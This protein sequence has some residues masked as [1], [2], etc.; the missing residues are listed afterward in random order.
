[1]GVPLSS[2]R[3]NHRRTAMTKD[4]YR[5]PV[6]VIRRD[7]RTLDAWKRMAERSP[8][9]VPP[10]VAKTLANRYPQLRRALGFG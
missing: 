1:M 9:A 8:A 4:Y 7:A 6:R 3:Q 2:C 5:T 10:Q